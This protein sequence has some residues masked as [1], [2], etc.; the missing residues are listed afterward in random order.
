MPDFGPFLVSG[1]AIGSV[2]AL[3]GLGVVM[4]YRTTSVVNFAYGAVGAVG[5]LTAW[6]LQQN[7]IA[8]WISW[9]AAI[10][11]STAM[12]TRKRGGVAR[13]RGVPHQSG[14]AAPTQG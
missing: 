8:E 9:A 13:R 4:L 12:S 6:E 3:S 10:L 2:Y 11:V 1:L 5:A 7:G 14:N